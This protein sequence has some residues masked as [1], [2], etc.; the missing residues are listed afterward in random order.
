MSNWIQLIGVFAARGA[1]PGKVIHELMIKAITTLYQHNAIVKAVVCD[2]AQ[3]NKQVMSLCGVNGKL[4]DTFENTFPHHL[5]ENHNNYFSFM[6][7]TYSSALGIIF[8][9]KRDVQVVNFYYL[10]QTIS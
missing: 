5:M 9:N 2:G 6:F 1:T 3:T 4:E 7:H 10:R 8:F